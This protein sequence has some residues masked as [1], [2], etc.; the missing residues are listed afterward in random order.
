VTQA[1]NN[2]LIAGGI[3]AAIIAAATIVVFL[4]QHR[5]LDLIRTEATRQKVRMAKN[6]ERCAAVP[7]MIREVQTLKNRYSNFNKR[8]PQQIELGGFLRE[9]SGDL[10]QVGLNNQLIQP[11]SPRRSELFHTLPI[12]LR[13]RGDYMSL[14]SFL[15]RLS[16]MERL[17]QVE[18][19]TISKVREEPGKGKAWQLDIE[20]LMNIYFTES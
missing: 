8:L 20:V 16:E 9:I 2:N 18:R 19:I 5:E 15:R 7:E 4:P 11:Q 6:A 13:F 1:T 17:T 3:M 12:L 14:A 10:S